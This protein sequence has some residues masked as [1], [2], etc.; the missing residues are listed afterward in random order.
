M[1]AALLLPFILSGILFITCSSGDS[2]PSDLK[3]DY[4]ES[5]MITV[6]NE[7]NL[8]LIDA[9]VHLD[10]DALLSKKP[11]FNVK[12]FVWLADGEEIPS[13]AV[14]TN[15]DG[16]LDQLVAVSDFNPGQTKKMILIYSPTG[17]KP[18]HYPA[19]TQAELSCKVGGKFEK[20]KKGRYEYTGGHFENVTYL[21][22]PPEHSDH[23]WYIR[24]EGP[25]W[26]SDKV[27]YR[28]YLDWRNATDIFGKKIP[29]MVLQNV[30][31]DGFDSYHE[32]SDW[33]MDILKVGDALGIGAVG[34]WV[35]NKAERVSRTDSLICSII[36]NGPVESRIRTEYWGWKVGNGQYNLT[37]D[38]TI[39]AGSR[40]T[41]QVVSISNSPDNLCTGIV[42]HEGVH[43]LQ[44]GN[45]DGNWAYLAT[46]GL[47]SLAGDSLGMAVIY[48][49][50]DKLELTQDSLNH[51]V[52]LKPENGKLTYYFL[53]A[54]E[55]EPGGI[56]SG[57][58]FKDY[59]D[60][61]L[62]QF[63]QPLQID[64]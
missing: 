21:K 53:A 58:E 24:Y 35:D 7:S 38:L 30:G 5:M 15:D 2:V 27:G 12:A 39:D 56:T 50:K 13:Q 44:S 52:I 46:Y 17:D 18:R 36:S 14:D 57:Q 19:R 59:L 45:E 20:N 11:N 31:Q 41:R 61:V 25:G 55:Q 64:I 22:V 3:K 16:K 43:V 60:N 6:S 40:L 54:W 63:D 26:E 37:S 32:M 4:P 8:R 33:G 49:K 1:K 9:P 62:T 28:F 23:S 10:I 34:M 51:V 47:Q 29:A 48:Q 42:K